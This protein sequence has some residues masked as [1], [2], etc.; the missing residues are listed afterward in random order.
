MNAPTRFV[1]ADAAA[2]RFGDR[3][4]RLGPLLCEADP[5]ADASV[6][7]LA[8]VARPER[9]AL[10]ER[11]LAGGASAVPDAPA[12]LRELV[13]AAS[14][15]PFWVDF[16]RVDRGGAAFL[17]SGVAGGFVLAFGSL[18]LSYCSPAGNKPLALSGQLVERAPRRLAETAR[19]VQLVSSAGAMRPHAPGWRTTLQVRLLH[20]EVRRGIDRSGR[21]DADRWGAPVNQVD[22]AGTALLFSAVLL[23][24]LRRIGFR[25]SAEDSE[26]LMHAWR[27]I[28]SVMGVRD[29]LLCAS[30][31]EARELWAM[32]E[33]T[34]G[35]PDDDSRTLA[36][37]LVTSARQT[38][39]TPAERA[40]AERLV[41]LGYGLS[42]HLLGDLRADALGYPRNAWSA[43]LP[44]LRL[45]VGGVDRALRRVPGSTGATLRA[46]AAYWRNVVEIGLGGVP[47]RFGLDEAWSVTGARTA[48]T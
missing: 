36:H 21:W 23:D 3:V 4:L 37:A 24:G 26:D 25:P 35:E 40:R 31:R 11:A 12:P 6:E 19:F 43:A 30:E 9:A 27:W 41:D 32:I 28:A 42:R 47:A 18:A 14:H 15:V 7:A 29:E 38:A 33:A 48:T 16:A 20:A 8:R 39:T 5:L 2:A 44:A 34:T 45:V 1:H 22:M 46:G 17:R 13:A 10:I